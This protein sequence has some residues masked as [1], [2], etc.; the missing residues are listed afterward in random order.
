MSD[1][2]D[3]LNKAAGLFVYVASPAWYRRDSLPTV[4]ATTVTI[5]ANTQVNVGSRGLV[6][7][8]DVTLSV[9][10]LDS[11]SNR[12]GRDVYIY[13]CINLTDT[14][15]FEPVFVLSYNSTVPAGYDSTNSRKIGGF[16][17]LCASVG[18]ISGHSLTGYTTGS[19]VPGSIWDL[20]HR[21]VSDPEGMVYCKPI[22]KWVDI[23]LP[24]WSGSK[25]QSVY[26]GTIVD[27]TSA[28]PMHGEMFNEYAGLVNK[29]LI[30]RDEFVV[31]SQGS[32]QCTN[33]YGSC[34]PTTTG[35]HVDTFSRRIISNYGIE[36]C[37]G[38]L[39]QWTRDCYEAMSVSWASG[40]T[41]MNGY[42]WQALPVYNSAMSGDSNKGSCL[43]LLRRAYVGGFWGDGSYCGSRSVVCNPFGTSVNAAF[44][45]RLV[46]EQRTIE[47]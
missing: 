3:A 8:S 23:Y 2:S 10:D 22:N 32:N 39:W 13:A 29:K 14:S 33:I 41:Y 5:P 21:P 28:K 43:G 20:R 36:D 15:S 44:S 25:L 35:G 30:S 40:N 34:D 11:A 9:D 7:K 12:A 46:S 31:I 24:S 16:H 6:S 38:V 17:C 37:C 27:G 26:G 1:L 19:I 45:A 47:I 4:T 18:S 42:S